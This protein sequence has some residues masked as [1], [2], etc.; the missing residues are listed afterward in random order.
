MAKKHEFKFRLSPN[1]ADFTV[2]SLQIKRE[3]V[4]CSVFIALIDDIVLTWSSLRHEQL[5]FFHARHALIILF[6]LINLLV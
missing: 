5:D 2:Y 6:L 3:E 1:V 4:L